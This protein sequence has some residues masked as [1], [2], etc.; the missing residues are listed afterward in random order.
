MTT[1]NTSPE[2]GSAPAAAAPLQGEHFHINQVHLE[3]VIARLWTYN[4]D[5]FGRLAIYDRHTQELPATPEQK[6][7]SQILAR[8]RRKAHFVTFRLV[9]GRTEDGMTTVS[10]QKGEKVKL[11]GYLEDHSYSEP[12]SKIWERLKKPERLQPGDEEIYVGRNS[13]EVIVQTIIRLS[14]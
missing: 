8:G 10:L 12:L 11:T 9:G 14:S 6:V 2:P 5:V 13:V 3:G 4:D 7:P 1:Q